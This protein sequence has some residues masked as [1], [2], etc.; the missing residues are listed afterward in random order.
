MA[1]KS[2]RDVGWCRQGHGDKQRPVHREDFGAEGHLSN[3]KTFP[4]DTL[5]YVTGF[6]RKQ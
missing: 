5:F 4:A 1:S 2:P 6:V 3:F